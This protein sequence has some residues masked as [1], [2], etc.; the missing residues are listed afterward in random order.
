MY[1]YLAKY[2]L[3]LEHLVRTFWFV[4]NSSQNTSVYDNNND[5][6]TTMSLK[7]DSNSNKNPDFLK[8]ESFLRRHDI[9][10]TKKFD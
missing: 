1:L 6:I 8:W 9:L 5:A 10:K 4:F 2:M 3:Y 7:R